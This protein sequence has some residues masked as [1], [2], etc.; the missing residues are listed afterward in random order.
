[1]LLPGLTVQLTLA[2]DTDPKTENK[3]IT[4]KNTKNN[5]NLYTIIPHNSCFLVIFIY[6]YIISDFIIKL[7]NNRNIIFSIKIIS[8]KLNT[9]KKMVYILKN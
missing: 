6:L 5:L 7:D 3:K 1:M 8:T 9:K 2:A 4:P